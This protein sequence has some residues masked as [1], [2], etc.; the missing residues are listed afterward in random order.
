MDRVCLLLTSVVDNFIDL[1]CDLDNLCFLFFELCRVKRNILLDSL[2]SFL[3]F[4]YVVTLTLGTLPGVVKPGVE[5]DVEV[6]LQ[7][8]RV[9]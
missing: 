2:H 9:R 5:G 7:E 8:E 4:F 3:L 1:Y 6:H